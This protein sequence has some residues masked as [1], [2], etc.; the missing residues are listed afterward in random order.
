MWLGLLVHAPKQI[1]DF[2]YIN[3]IA[4]NSHTAVDNEL[5]QNN[6]QLKIIWNVVKFPFGPK[7]RGKPAKKCSLWSSQKEGREVAQISTV[8]IFVT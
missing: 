2:I 4:H 7:I 5:K 6:A 8:C 1:I 3:E